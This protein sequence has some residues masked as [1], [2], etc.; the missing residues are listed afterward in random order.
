MALIGIVAEEMI[1]LLTFKK[2]PA[3]LREWNIVKRQKDVSLLLSIPSNEIS[4]S[5]PSFE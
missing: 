3:I 4:E 5:L 2:P 1:D